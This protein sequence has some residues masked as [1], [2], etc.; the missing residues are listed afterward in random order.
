MERRDGVRRD[1]LLGRDHPSRP[2]DGRR[3]DCG[4]DAQREGQPSLR[5]VGNAVEA[6]LNCEILV[7]VDLGGLRDAVEVGGCHDR[8]GLVRLGHH[9]EAHDGICCGLHEPQG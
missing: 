9:E 3:G 2:G 8:Y 4:G 5:R 1:D 6:H 7:V